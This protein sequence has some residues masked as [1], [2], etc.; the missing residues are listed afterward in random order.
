MERLLVVTLV[1]VADARLGAPDRL[2]GDGVSN[3]SAGVAARF[4]AGVVRLHVGGPGLLA[5]ES[6]LRWLLF[7]LTQLLLHKCVRARVCIL[8]I[9]TI[10]ILISW[11]LLHLHLDCRAKAVDAARIDQR[12]HLKELHL[13]RVMKLHIQLLIL[14]LIAPL[15]QEDLALD[16]ICDFQLIVRNV[17][18]TTHLFEA[19]VLLKQE[20]A[21]ARDVLVGASSWALLIRI[22][23]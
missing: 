1:E 5:E 23:V 14:I 15:I 9:R 19:V 13:R 7:T 6:G 22:T 8:K 17:F 10:P 4:A 21:L 2:V 3:D 12:S 16:L 11:I 18:G 20:V